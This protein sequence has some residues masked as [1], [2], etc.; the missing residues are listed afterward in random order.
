MSAQSPVISDTYRRLQQ[1]LHENPGY[2]VMSLRYGG[3]VKQLIDQLGA[4]SLTDYGAG[5][6]NLLT[7]LQKLDVEIDYRPYDPAFPEYG[8]AQQ[9]DLV[10]C[11]DVLEHIEPDYL[12][13]V[14]DELKAIT[15]KH[16]FFTVHVGPA[17][18]HL[19][20]GRNA[21]LI[22]QPPQWWLPKFKERFKLL[23][24]REIANGF[25]VIVAAL[26]PVQA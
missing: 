10:C 12:E 5:K 17:V 7:A 26:D 22:Q 4:K 15:V 23:Q 2:G 8:Q 1:E 16:G 3:I 20:D 18:K 25:A 19:A 13:N 24:T 9:A 14:L 11:I 6:Q 21:H